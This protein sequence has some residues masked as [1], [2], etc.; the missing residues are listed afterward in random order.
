MSAIESFDF[1]GQQITL[2][3]QG[4][5]QYVLLGQLCSHMGLDV[6]AQQRALDR[7]VWAQGKTAV[8]AV[9]LPGDVQARNRY[10]IDV[11]IVGMWLANITSSRIAD[12]HA[13]QMVERYQVELTQ[14]I[15]EWLT[16]PAAAPVELDRRALALMVIEAEDARV[17]AE[18]RAVEA[19]Q[20][21][22]HIE[23]NDGLTVRDFHK[24]YFSEHGEREVNEFFY[25]QGLLI[26]ERGK[27]WDERTQRPKDGKNHRRPTYTG[28][29]FF[30]LHSKLDRD[31]V[32]REE[33]RV[34]PGAPELALVEY[35]TKRG[36]TA[37]RSESKELAA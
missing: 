18:Q 8:M 19:E 21:Q 12:P 33:T 30:Y 7:Q 36:F 23:L 37:N 17:A 14:R 25:V 34:R 2:V 29:P 31:K 16:K 13:R 5:E 22:E 11:K 28:K 1:Y 9:Q 10:L 24:K 20:F 6:Q 26:D 27:R 3:E 32:R 15:H 4:G 35:M